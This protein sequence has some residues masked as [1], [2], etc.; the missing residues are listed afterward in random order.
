[1]SS[2]KAHE[3]GSSD[4]EVGV[5]PVEGQRLPPSTGHILGS[6]EPHIFTNPHR[7]AHWREVY[8]SATYE[9]RHRFEPSWTW[10]PKEELRLI[11]KVKRSFVSSS[12]PT[13]EY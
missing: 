9:G 7:A 2:E 10:S 3:A 6:T 1:M 13:N 8:D 11:K 4:S 12:T 5:F